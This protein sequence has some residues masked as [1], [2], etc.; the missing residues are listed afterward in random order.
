M[1]AAFNQIRQTASGVPAVLIRMAENIGQLLQQADKEHRPALEKQL[2]L[3]VRAGR[4]SIDEKDDLKDMEKS[5]QAAT[6]GT[7][8]AEE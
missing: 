6:K 5:A 4:R 8:K 3:V 7:G 1:D 2:A